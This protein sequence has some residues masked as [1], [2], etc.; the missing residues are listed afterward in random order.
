VSEADWDD[1]LASE[2]W[3]FEQLRH[4]QTI[5]NKV[6]KALLSKIAEQQADRE[7]DPDTIGPKAT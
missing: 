6:L 4:L 2:E 3:F 1:V 5:D 7:K